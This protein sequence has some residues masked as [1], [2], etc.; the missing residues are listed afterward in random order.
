[1]ENYVRGGSYNC[2]ALCAVPPETK[3]EKLTISKNITHN[4]QKEISG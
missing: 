3:G 2:V 4:R 1:M